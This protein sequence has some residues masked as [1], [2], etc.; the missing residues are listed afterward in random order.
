MFSSAFGVTAAALGYVEPLA[1]PFFNIG[2]AYRYSGTG[3]RWVLPRGMR[4]A[5]FVEVKWKT[6]GEG[7]ERE[8]LGAYSTTLIHTATAGR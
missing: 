2:W 6:F 8:L 4:H 7:K 1:P 3:Q 5:H